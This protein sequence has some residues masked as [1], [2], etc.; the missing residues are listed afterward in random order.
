M[1]EPH[2]KVYRLVEGWCAR[3][4]PLPDGRRQII[5]VFLP[6]DLFGIK[7]MF[8]T[9]QPDGIEAIT[10]SVVSWADYK[11]LRQLYD[12]DRDA[13]LRVLWQVIEDERRLHTWVVSLGRGNAEERMAEMLLTFRGRLMRHGDSDGGSYRMPMTQQQI[14]DLLGLTT[15]HV[16]RVLKRFRDA[17]LATVQKGTAVLHDVERLEKLAYPLQDT[18]ER[19]NPEFGGSAQ[20]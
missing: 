14:G 5:A 13:A 17:R 1:A 4:R 6:H 9:R 12:D 20:S 15:V 11:S 3:T 2:E 8:M 18:F 7:C 19:S 16:N 10:D